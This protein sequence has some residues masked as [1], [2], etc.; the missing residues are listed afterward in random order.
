MLWHGENGPGS[1]SN[2]ESDIPDTSFV[3]ADQPAAWSKK[4][5]EVGS[6]A[7]G[8]HACLEWAIS[9]SLLLVSVYVCVRLRM[10]VTA[11]WHWSFSRGCHPLII[12]FPGFGAQF[13]GKGLWINMMITYRNPGSL[14]TEISSISHT[15][16]SLPPP[17][18]P[19]GLRLCKTIPHFMI[20]VLGHNLALMQGVICPLHWGG[21]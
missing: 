4:R 17:P 1:V 2:H 10:C 13:E 19:R 3:S 15:A 11:L 12:Y 21:N 18:T 20:Y 5:Q 16:A 14:K 7:D 9:A 8:R 6:S